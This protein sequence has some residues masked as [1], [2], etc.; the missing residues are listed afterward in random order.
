MNPALILGIG[1]GAAALFFIGRKKGMLPG[2][3]PNPAVDAP[4]QYEVTQP[5]SG[6]HGDELT[7]HT[8][9]RITPE[10]TVGLVQG[11]SSR[12]QAIQLI[13][14]AE[15][16]IGP[17][18]FAMPHTV[19]AAVV[20]LFSILGPAA[21]QFQRM[22]AAL[23]EWNFNQAAK[24]VM[25]SRFARQRSAEANRI[26]ARMRNAGDQPKPVRIV[27]V[28]GPQGQTPPASP[29]QRGTGQVIPASS[30][31]DYVTHWEGYREQPYR[32]SRGIWT[33]GVG[34]NLEAHG[35]RLTRPPFNTT[36]QAVISGQRRL[37]RQEIE[38]LLREEL[39]S[40]RNAAI[41]MHPDLGTHPPEIQAIVIDLIYNVG[42]AG[43]RGFRNTRAALDRKDYARF[44]Q[45]LRNSRWYGQVGR[46]SKHHVETVEAIV[47]GRSVP[48][49][50]PRV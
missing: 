5:L 21:T 32:D 28:G 33:V 20:E 15:G 36:A 8:V 48:P 4:L 31:I 43:W 19:Q 49:I 47:A 37:T 2:F 45:G 14:K 17:D 35:A 1:A 24:E 10:K 39:E 42:E 40:A 16:F 27:P 34:F 3:G 46:R 38:L 13:N 41:R 6:L 22:R 7:T 29:A 50:Q 30:L 44:A 25:D 26:A 12:E 18:L 23:L 9:D 11:V